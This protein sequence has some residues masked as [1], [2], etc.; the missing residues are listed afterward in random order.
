MLSLGVTTRA[1]G[2]I[3]FF[4]LYLGQV[5][6]SRFFVHAHS[7]FFALQANEGGKTN[8]VNVDR[9]L[10]FEA[11]DGYSQCQM[12]SLGVT[13]RAPGPIVFFS[14][15]GMSVHPRFSPCQWACAACVRGCQ[16]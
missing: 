7:F 3:L 12:L 4:R 15:G 13:T 9:Y 2:P 1:P 14:I 5:P 6:R 16:R 11:L 8:Q 10:D